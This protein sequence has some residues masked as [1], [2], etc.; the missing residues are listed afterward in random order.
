MARKLTNL[1]HLLPLPLQLHKQQPK[2]VDNYKS[3]RHDGMGRLQLD[4]SAATVTSSSP[5]DVV[6]RG[7]IQCKTCWN[8]FLLI[9][10]GV[11]INRVI[12]NVVAF[13]PVRRMQF[14]AS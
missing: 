9:F 10:S 2:V 12:L 8:M 5:H 7:R 14:I 3:Q 4:A 11:E 1:H 6:V 13:P